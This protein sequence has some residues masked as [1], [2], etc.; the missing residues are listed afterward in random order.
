MINKEQKMKDPHQSAV[1]VKLM[2]KAS[3]PYVDDL[4][5]HLTRQQRKPEAEWGELLKVFAGF[6]GLRLDRLYN[7]VTPEQ[8]D[9][10]VLRA[11][12]WDTIPW[13][14][15]YQPTRKGKDRSPDP[16]TV[17]KMM[18]PRISPPDPSY[19]PPNFL[20]FF[21]TACADLD[22]AN[23]LADA[24]DGV[25]GIEYAYVAPEFT[26]P[27]PSPINPS[28]DDPKAMHAVTTLGQNGYLDANPSGVNARHAWAQ[29]WGGQGVTVVDVEQGWSLLHPD[30]P[31]SKISYLDAQHGDDREHGTQTL[32]V[33]CASDNIMGSIGLAPNVS[34][35]L[36]SYNLTD[37]KLNQSLCS[38]QNLW[39]SLA[40]AVFALVAV[41]TGSRV[42]PPGSGNI[43]LIEAQT[44][45][46]LPVEVDPAVC[47][48]IR[49]LVQNE[50]VVIE[51]A[52]NSGSNLDGQLQ[53]DSGAIMVAAGQPALTNGQ[54][55][56]YSYSNFGSRVDCYA[57][58]DQV[59]TCAD[60]SQHSGQLY[61]NFTSTSAA[62]AI[63]AGVAAV[64]QSWAIAKQGRPFTPI[65]LRPKLKQNG[66]GSPDA[67]GVMPDLTKII[68]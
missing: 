61:F 49:L 2:D 28:D 56:R 68:P 66:T 20:T 14:R 37:H 64:V 6:P 48:T 8:L 3:V 33:L 63:I 60:P 10:L 32:G 53:S 58:G 25:R 57:W 31:K 4:I 59:L 40:S 65:E 30:L 42:R 39:T 18:A 45:S 12:G 55:R 16:S 34:V 44:S 9:A 46:G 23:A 52:G 47:E 13:P 24:L 51:A 19:Q 5:E 7:S 35:R 54:H 11:T 38:V 26:D 29:G 15:A 62:S 27:A 67:I 41:V 21:I 36:C 50:L 17:S 43:V 1:V 22:E